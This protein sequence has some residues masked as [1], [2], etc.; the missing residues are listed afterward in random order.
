ME[1]TTRR[2]QPRFFDI[3]TLIFWFKRLNLESRLVIEEKDSLM[4]GL[5]YP[6][7]PWNSSLSRRASTLNQIQTGLGQKFYPFTLLD[8]YC[9]D[10]MLA[11][12]VLSQHRVSSSK[13]FKPAT[14]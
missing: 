6:T 4:M 3:V 12:V 5:S 14:L 2:F 13:T 11:M 10:Q 8:F 9:R 7:Q 1:S